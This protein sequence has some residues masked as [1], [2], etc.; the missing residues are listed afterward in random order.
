MR[1]VT[2]VSRDYV[3]LLR[4]WL[5]VSSAHM[6]VQPAVIAMDEPAFAEAS[7]DPRCRPVLAPPAVGPVANRGLFW[8]RRLTLLLDEMLGT[9]GL[10][11]HSDLDAFWLKDIASLLAERPFDLAFSMDYG[12]PADIG[13]QWGFTLCPGLFAARG[14]ARL[15][16]FAQRWLAETRRYTDDQNAINYLLRDLDIAWRPH[17]I[18]GHEG[19]I[20]EIEIEGRR[21]TVLALSRSLCDRVL[22][23]EDDRGLMVAHPF[24]DGRFRAATVQL[25]ARLAASRGLPEA[26]RPAFR[27]D[28]RPSL[29]RNLL[30]RAGFA[31]TDQARLT[32][33]ELH[34]F[35]GLEAI[36]GN[37]GKAAS[38]FEAALAKGADPAAV[39]VD[40]HMT[41]HHLGR[42][43]EARAALA[44]ALTARQPSRLLRR[45]GANARTIGAPSLA[46]RAML[47]IV[48]LSI[49]D[50]RR[51]ARRLARVARRHAV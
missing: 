37:A 46:A 32:A 3:D 4:L 11:V 40:S 1:I 25:L 22:P 14:G 23:L 50:P 17:T 51:I 45:L 34:Y 31:A 39:G 35:A 38:L 49:G 2:F 26:S 12:H 44:A 43:A 15:S 18:G 6:P 27:G 8:I 48:F 47:Q 5:D 28:E 10:V 21:L 16:A 30:L 13:A 24:F 41:F 36:H 42:K 9:D 7:A 20:G 19:A 33:Q 29:R